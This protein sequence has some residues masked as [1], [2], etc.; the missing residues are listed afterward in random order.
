MDPNSLTPLL[1]SRLIVLDKNPGVCPI[2]VR[3]VARRLISKT[4]LAILKD[5]ILDVTGTHQLC[6]GQ[7]AGCKAAIHTIRSIFDNPDCEAIL[8]IEAIRTHSTLLTENLPFGTSRPFVLC[9]P[10][11]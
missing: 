7:V 6:A 3:E 2:G 8:L 4:I 5:D 11:Q 9:S 1:G 10:P